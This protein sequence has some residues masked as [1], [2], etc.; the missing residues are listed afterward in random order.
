[1]VTAYSP[2]GS[3]ATTIETDY[4][5]Q[6]RYI[7]EKAPKTNPKEMFREDLLAQLRKWRTRGDIM[8]LVMDTN[9]DVIDGA[10]CKQL[11]R[12]DLNMKEVVFSQTRTRGPKTYFR[13]TVAIDDLWVSEELEVTAAAYLPFNLELGDHQ[14]VVVNI[15]KTSTLGVSGPKIKP[16]A[17]RRLNSK[18]KQIRQKYII[19]LKEEFRKHRILEQL[20]TLE[21]RA[22]ESF[23]KHAKEALK[24]LT[25]V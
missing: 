12:A 25:L 5:Q 11:N 1:M 22:D 19:K 20:A 9:K 24:T 7:V 21:E 17:A 15:T 6:A 14:P 13:G 8:I 2:F 18:V 10:M 16:C 4:Q 23:S 3:A